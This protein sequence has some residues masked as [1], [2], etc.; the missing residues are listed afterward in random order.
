[1]AT[2]ICFGNWTDQGMRNVKDG[3]KRYEATKGLI[4]KLGGRLLS[5]HITARQYDVVPTADMPNGEATP[6]AAIAL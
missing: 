5:A 1:M 2:F 4:E 6:K 3:P